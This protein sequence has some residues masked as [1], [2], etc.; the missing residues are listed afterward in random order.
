MEP[1]AG[2]ALRRLQV[3]QR[4]EPAQMLLMESY[5]PGDSSRSRTER[6]RDG[7]G[8]GAARLGRIDSQEKYGARGSGRG[9][10][11]STAAAARRR[12]GTSHLGSRRGHG[13]GSGRRRHRQRSGRLPLDFAQGDTLARNEGRHRANPR[14][15][16]R[17]V[18]A[19][20]AVMRQDQQAAA[21]GSD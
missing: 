7:A 3:S 11:V 1:L 4:S 18:A 14:I 13:A 10:P 2:G 19:T 16:G 20:T 5:E 21:A 12:L 15:H 6:V 8:L 9:R 17:V